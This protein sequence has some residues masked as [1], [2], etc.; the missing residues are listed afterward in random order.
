MF[1]LEFGSGMGG[2]TMSGGPHRVTTESR[3]YQQT[4]S[5]QHHAGGPGMSPSG[6]GGMN[7]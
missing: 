7:Q 2:G 1:H 5:S 4:M 3:H 6:M